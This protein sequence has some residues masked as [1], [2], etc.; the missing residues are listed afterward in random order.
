MVTGNSL[1]RVVQNLTA[2]FEVCV[3]H[4]KWCT[5]QAETAVN[6]KIREDFLSLAQRWLKLAG[7]YERSLRSQTG[8]GK[9]EHS[10]LE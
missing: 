5:N 8:M 1:G 3:K 7:G 10:F 9:Q 6:K 4:A 2:E